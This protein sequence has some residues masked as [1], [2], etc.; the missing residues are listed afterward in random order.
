MKATKTYAVFGLGRYGRAVARTL[1]KE[2]AEVLAVDKNEALVNALAAEIPFCKCAD[3]TDPDVLS[4]LGIS[5]IDTVIIA[6]STNLEA[7]VL[8]VMLCR[9]AGVKNVIAKGAD[10]M[11]CRIL[12]R[13]GADAAVIPESEAGV[14]F[15]K[16]LLSAGFVDLLD[17]SD[18][19][20]IAEIAIRAEWVGKTLVELSLRNRFGLNVVAL[21]GADGLKIHID[22]HAPLPEK[23]Q[24]IVIAETEK[25]KNLKAN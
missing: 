5:E 22:P 12:E 21:R 14:R 20:S 25:V 16:T 3:V 4:A 18:D 10:D 11:Q 24:L 19:F 15:A 9:E 6:M 8:A 1:A 13:V 7:S 2:G 17:L 23:G